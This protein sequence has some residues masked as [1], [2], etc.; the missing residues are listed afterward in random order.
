MLNFTFVINSIRNQKEML[1]QICP[2][3]DMYVHKGE[4]RTEKEKNVN[5]NNVWNNHAQ[6]YFLLALYLKSILN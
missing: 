4:K 2:N 1:E 5:N 6:M 3:K